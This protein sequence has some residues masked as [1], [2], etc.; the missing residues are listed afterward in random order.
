MVWTDVKG[1][2]RYRRKLLMIGVFYINLQSVPSLIIEHK[3]KISLFSIIL[4][5]VIRIL[6]NILLYS[7]SLAK[8]VVNQGTIIT[9]NL[10]VL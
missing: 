8:H 3:A 1:L 9:I 4:K 6:I 5:K 2:T 7:L 10:Q